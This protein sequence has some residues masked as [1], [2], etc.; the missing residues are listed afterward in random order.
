MAGKLCP[1]DP[2]TGN[3]IMYTKEP[4]K[5]FDKDYT[6]INSYRIV[7]K[8][9]WWGFKHIVLEDQNGKHRFMS[10]EDFMDDINYFVKGTITGTFKFYKTR[11]S[12][13]IRM[14]F[15]K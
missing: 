5:K 4:W 14:K 13:N 8:N 9:V 6:E 7:G 11:G 3:Q 10:L 12:G 1:I 2:V 15:I